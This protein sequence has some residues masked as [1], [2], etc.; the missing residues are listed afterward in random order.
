MA[1]AEDMRVLPGRIVEFERE[2]LEQQARA[3]QATATLQGM[4]AQQ[5][6]SEAAAQ[7]DQR[8]AAAFQTAGNG[9]SAAV[10]A[11]LL[12]KTSGFRWTR[13]E[14]VIV[15]VP[16]RSLLWCNRQSSEGSAGVT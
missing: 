1:A 16:V 2:L 11:K 8:Q 15:Q 5:Q 6:Q 10:D 7:Q 12:G 4:Q 14:L 3:D 9:A 13:D